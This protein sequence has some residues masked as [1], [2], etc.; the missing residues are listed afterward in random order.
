MTK[1]QFDSYRFSV[2][3]QIKVE[4]KWRKVIEL[5]FGRRCINEFSLNQI[6]EIR[7]SDHLL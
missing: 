5:D 4:G 7:E 1:K 6:E 3:T 2:N